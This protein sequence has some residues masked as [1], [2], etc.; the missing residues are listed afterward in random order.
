MDRP[1]A[2]SKTTHIVNYGPPPSSRHLLADGSRWKTSAGIGKRGPPQPANRYNLLLYLKGISEDQDALPLLRNAFTSKQNLGRD[3]VISNAG[4]SETKLLGNDHAATL[5]AEWDAVIDLARVVWQNPNNLEDW[6]T[7]MFYEHFRGR[8]LR[9]DETKAHT[10]G[11]VLGWADKWAEV[12]Y[13][14]LNHYLRDDPDHWM[15]ADQRAFREAGD[16]ANEIVHTSS[17]QDDCLLAESNWFAPVHRALFFDVYRLGVREGR[18]LVYLSNWVNLSASLREIF[19]WSIDFINRYIHWREALMR[20]ETRDH[21]NEVRRNTQLSQQARQSQRVVFANSMKASM[22]G[23]DEAYRGL[24]DV[25]RA[26]MLEAREHMKFRRNSWQQFSTI[27]DQVTH[28]L[29]TCRL[30][31]PTNNRNWDLR[32][33]WPKHSAQDTFLPKP[34]APDARLLIV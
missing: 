16:H 25:L 29:R 27:I 1:P 32:Q 9:D 12:R 24:L 13:R 8:I 15:R 20:A 34:R 19:R 14:Y 30:N 26:L 2:L 11:R 23:P 10:L 31:R 3:Y 17:I 22:R 7:H 28:N 4:I 21:L 5:I 18:R 33:N 6:I